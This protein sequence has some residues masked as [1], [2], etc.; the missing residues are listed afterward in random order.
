MMSL[1][2]ELQDDVAISCW[3]VDDGQV[4][5]I[6][7]AEVLPDWLDQDPTDNHRYACWIRGGAI[8]LLPQSHIS[9]SE[10]LTSLRNKER[11]TVSSHPKVQDLL[12]RCFSLNKGQAFAKQRTPLVVPRKVAT[13]VRRR[14]DLV[15]AAIQSFCN[16]IEYPPPDLV[17]YDDWVW[18]TASLSRT[19]YA[20]LRTMVSTQWK[21][22]DFVPSTGV[23]IKRFKRQCKMESTPHLRYAVTL[24]V[25][26]VAGLEF[27]AKAKWDPVS[28]EMR[29][30]YWNRI[31]DMCGVSERAILSSFTQ[32]PNHAQHD[33]TDILKC[34]VSP[35]EA[36]NP[37]LY[38]Y[39]ETSIKQQ[40]NDAQK[41]ADPNED[42]LMPQ[43]DQVDDEDWMTLDYDGGLEGNND[44]DRILSRFQT[45]MV[46][47]AEVEGVAA[48]TAPRS[49]RDIRPRIVMNM[50][51]AVLKGKA[52]AFPTAEDPFFYQEDYDLMEESSGDNGDAEDPGLHGLMVSMARLVLLLVYNNAPC[53]MS[54]VNAC[55]R[56]QWMPN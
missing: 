51:H 26:L 14:P 30:S 37:T 1:S 46:Q 2:R 7:T 40:I 48:A 18:T 35:E 5:L 22:V 44:L 12:Q 17:A 56:M 33:L 19:N 20:M 43:V 23:E 25:R 50:L 27:L 6:Q 11:Y 36:E 16:R 42:F 41:A 31:E 8:Q 53:N 38:S 28:T 32:G 29:I 15:H 49:R 9:L 47:P 45:F 54:N 4:I 52:I 55:V 39:P 10:A 3:D 24:G 21:T 13:L 34:P